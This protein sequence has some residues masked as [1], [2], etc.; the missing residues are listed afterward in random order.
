MALGIKWTYTLELRP[1]P[2]DPDNDNSYGFLLPA[3]Y[4]IPTAQ[5]AWA[6]I[7]DVAV[8]ALST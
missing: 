4:I 5:E 2:T 3:S 8:K 1:G 6:G 7:I